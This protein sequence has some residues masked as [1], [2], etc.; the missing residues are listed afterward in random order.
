MYWQI[1]GQILGQ[2]PGRLRR[3]IFLS[4]LIVL[5]MFIAILLPSVWSTNNATA[6]EKSSKRRVSSEVSRMVKGK[7]AEEIF[8]MLTE[9]NEKPVPEATVDEVA[10]FKQKKGTLLVGMADALLNLEPDDET[11]GKTNMM[12]I[13]GLGLLMQLKP[14]DVGKINAL[15]KE[16]EK[17]DKFPEVVAQCEAY[18]YIQKIRKTFL[19]RRVSEK[20]FIR[21][22]KELKPLI[23]EHPESPYISAAGLLLAAASAYE[24]NQN[25]DGFADKFRDEFVRTFRESGNE[26]L[27]K[28]AAQIEL[29]ANAAVVPGKRITI[30][31][32]TVDGKL[33]DVK[34]LRGKVVLI[35]FWA[36]W[37]GPCRGEI[38]GMK[39]CY[40]KY[41]SKGFEIVGISTDKNIGE[42]KSFLASEHIPWISVSDTMT[43]SAGMPSLKERYGI[44]GI[45]TMYLLDR[46]GRVISTSAR[47][48]MLKT[49]L[50]KEFGR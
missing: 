28:I 49:L 33:F 23:T 15:K 12:K 40:A 32:M 44:R 9:L 8:E 48:A 46:Q 31:G 50:E 34:A 22:A 11:A 20:D 7:S 4:C 47:G 10:E 26:K 42:L 1:L 43:V 24:G 13:G 18:L 41:R 3:Q 39:E 27:L 37:C 30:S 16:L 2:I 38:P 45:P 5:S 21:V 36:T 6:Q 14:D 25:L 29:D 19:S 35:D 17:E